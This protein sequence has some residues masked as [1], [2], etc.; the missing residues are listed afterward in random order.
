M[1]L[2]KLR[3]FLVLI[4]ITIGCDKTT[5]V[6]EAPPDDPRRYTESSSRTGFSYLP[7]EGWK[8]ETQPQGFRI[9]RGE[10]TD[11]V[12]PYIMIDIGLLPESFD[13]LIDNRRSDYSVSPSNKNISEVPFQTSAGLKGTKFVFERNGKT[14]MQMYVLDGGNRYF[15]FQCAASV[16]SGDKFDQTFDDAVKSLWASPTWKPVTD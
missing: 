4:L 6:A 12:S 5:K 11:G 9:A 14:R 2:R 10:V 1:T 15:Q 7:P 3:G 8:L 13:K 16:Q